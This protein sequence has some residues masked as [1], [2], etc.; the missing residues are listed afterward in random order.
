MGVCESTA[1][2]KLKTSEGSQGDPGRT[3]SAASYDPDPARQMYAPYV[4]LE[5]Q[6]RVM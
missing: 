6:N 5:I 3:N 1:L 2:E 4:A